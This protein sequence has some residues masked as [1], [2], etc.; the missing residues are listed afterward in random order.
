MSCPNDVEPNGQ[1]SYIVNEH[2]NYWNVR[3]G[4]GL[5][6]GVLPSDVGC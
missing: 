6:L 3:Y 4:T 5:P 1:H 2:M